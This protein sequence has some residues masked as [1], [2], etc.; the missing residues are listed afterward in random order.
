MDVNRIELSTK[1]LHI[2]FLAF[3]IRITLLSTGYHD[4]FLEW[5][6]K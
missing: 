1:S 5:I 2:S 4:F 3:H 6:Y